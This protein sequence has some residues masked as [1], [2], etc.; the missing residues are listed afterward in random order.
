[1]RVLLTGA[2]GFIG[3][4][5]ARSFAARGDDVVAFAGDLREP[6]AFAEPFDAVVHLAQSRRY[7]DPDGADDVRAV[8]VEA[9]GRLIALAPATFVLAS[10]GSVYAP[11]A[12]PIREEDELGATGTYAESK[13]AAEEL[14]RARGGAI[15]RFF[16]VYGPG[17]RGMLVANLVDRVLAGE[18]VEV[19]DLT[20]NPI[21]VEDAARA[22]VAATQVGR[23]LTANVAGDEA[24]SLADLVAKIQS[25]AGR[26]APVAVRPG[27]PRA[28]VGANDRMKHELGVSPAWTLERG[29]AATVA[30]YS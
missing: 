24:V 12:D 9:T 1:V 15:L 26:S 27:A 25:L 28:L 11:R 16:T 29:L 4:H 7:R 5:V 6:F 23:S 19:D 30:A 22:V 20:I 17:Q 3:S 10:S 13:Q 14:V 18:P 21:Y 2:S 8:N